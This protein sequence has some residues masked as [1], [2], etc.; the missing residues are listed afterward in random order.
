MSDYVPPKFNIQT[1]T[2]LFR[3]DDRDRIRTTATYID[4]PWEIGLSRADFNNPAV[5]VNQLALT[6]IIDE[7]SQ[8]ELT[9]GVSANNDGAVLD[10]GVSTVIVDDEDRKLRIY[11]DR[12]LNDSDPRA[13]EALIQHNTVGLVLS[14]DSLQFRYQLAANSDAVEVHEG[15]LSYPLTD[16][17]FLTLKSYVRAA[18]EESDFFWS[19]ELF[20]AT[21]IA[22]GVPFEL[23]NNTECQAG[24]QPGLALT[25]DFGSDTEIEFAAP[26]GAQCQYSA[27]DTQ[28]KGRIGLAY[29]LT[30]SVEARF[31]F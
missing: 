16:N 5:A 6:F 12:G 21:G 25:S 19:P 3:P 9:A 4:G 15:W 27:G 24:V 18:S 2:T 13:I 10:F 23:G 8:T 26:F 1:Q 7:G 28:I 31:S 29:G 22:M 20:A 17:G 11:F 14:D 30:A